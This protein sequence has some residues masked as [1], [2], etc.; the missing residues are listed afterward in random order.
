MLLIPG[1]F[2]LDTSLPHTPVSESDSSIPSNVIDVTSEVKEVK[3][4]VVLGETGTAIAETCVQGSQQ[5]TAV[6]INETKTVEQATSQVGNGN[7]LSV[8]NTGPT[9]SGGAEQTPNHVIVVANEIEGIQN[10]GVQETTV[11]GT[12]TKNVQRSPVSQGK[13]IVDDQSSFVK[14]N[15]GGETSSTDV[16]NMA[17]EPNKDVLSSN[18]P[19]FARHEGS[20]NGV[21]S[22]INGMKQQ[23]VGKTETAVAQ[24]V[25]QETQPL[26][27]VSIKTS[28]NET[29]T[30]E[31]TTSLAGNGNELNVSDAGP[32]AVPGS[33]E[34]TSNQVI[35]VANEIEGNKQ[36]VVQETIVSETVKCCVQP[37]P[38]SPET[39]TVEEPNSIG[40]DNEGSETNA[41]HIATLQFA[42]I[43]QLLED[44]SKNLATA[45]VQ[46]EDKGVL[47]GKQNNSGLSPQCENVGVI[48]SNKQSDTTEADDGNYRCADGLINDPDLRN[49]KK[50]LGSEILGSPEIIEV[51]DKFYVILEDVQTVETRNVEE[52]DEQSKKLADDSRAKTPKNDK[53]KELEAKPNAKTDKNIAQNTVK[54]KE[55]EKAN[56]GM[57]PADVQVCSS[58]V[59][60]LIL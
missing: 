48:N 36:V 4:N 15:E 10:I 9:V 12:L 50:P 46:V 60:L 23:V 18:E 2:F 57:Q 20:G 27:A 5:L 41:E 35:V 56:K 58:S 34:Q 28:V 55:S 3:Q 59:S 21:A 19:D 13:T 25:E 24:I 43:D 38:A 53:K 39:R 22:N 17:Q 40:K 37:S 29:K 33:P 26:T 51:L 6:S 49:N 42:K 7:E 32:T 1:L 16:D 14:G 8:S 45:P 11:T 30:F 44:I 47:Q 31:Q 54:N 52:C